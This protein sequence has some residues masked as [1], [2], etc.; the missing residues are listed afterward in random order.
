MAKS[1]EVPESQGELLARIAAAL[2]RL[3]PAALEAEAPRTGDA[4]L[5]EPTHGGLLAVASVASLPL[6]L[7]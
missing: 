7:L 1:K 3:A 6:A 4:F 5:W 2:E